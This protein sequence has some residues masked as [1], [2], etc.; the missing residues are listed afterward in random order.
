MSHC[1]AKKETMTRNQLRALQHAALVKRLAAEWGFEACGISRARRLTEHESRLE[2]WLLAGNH[3]EM[4]YMANHFD[5]RLDP[6]LLVPGARSVVSLLFN[7]FP[8]NESPSVG[9]AKIARYAYGTDYHFVIKNR[10]KSL[11][12]ALRD[13]VGAVEGRVFADSAP[14]MERQWAALS[15]LGWT[16]RNSLLLNAKKGSYFFLCEL[17]IDLELAP[18]SPTANRCGTCTRCVDACPTEALSHSGMLDARK[19]ISYLTIELKNAIPNEFHE[20]MNGWIFGCDIC[21][22]VCPFNRF[23]SPHT[24]PEFAPHP[25][26]ESATAADWKELTEDV[27]REVF[28]KSAV[29]RTKFTGLKRNIEVAL[30]PHAKL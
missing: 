8:G 23:S 19:C 22:E 10:L 2:Q 7:Y 9:E 28:R 1:A 13:A 25:F 14:V 20:Q 21:Q 17:I 29:K 4:H 6:T 18:D 12:S 24:E 26:L 3:G 5:M 11:L 30:T 27:F 15:G 16:G